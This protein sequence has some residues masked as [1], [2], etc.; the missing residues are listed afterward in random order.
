[1]IRDWSID[2]LSDTKTRPDEAMRSAMA[3]ARVGDEQQEEDPTVDHLRKRVAALFGKPQ[4]VFL[5]S[6]TMANLI[7]I[8][9][10]C[11]RGDEI[12]A[13]ASS[14]VLH[15]ETGGPAG[16][17]GATVTALPGQRGMFGLQELSQAL[18][19][20]RRNA[21][22]PRLVWIEQT[23][24]LAGG[25]VWPLD[26][27]RPIR[28]FCD[29][30]GLLL[31]IDGARLMNAAIAHRVEAAAYGAVADSLWL[32]FSKG[33]GAP[34]GAVLA[35]SEAFVTAAIRYKHM[36][37]GA[38][39]QG[40]IMAAACLHALDHN[41]ER[42][43]DD[44]A[45]AKALAE[46]LR[47]LK[48]IVIDGEVETNIVIANLDSN[49]RLDARGVADALASRGIRVGV[50]GPRTMR[51]VTHLH[52]TAEDVATTVSAMQEIMSS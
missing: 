15:F 46:G 34:F 40:G 8:L 35:G 32:D 13:E 9:V 43:A 37:G 42:L 12:L 44:H 11:G 25:T 26:I 47:E 6:G 41:I 33:L 14:H 50:F 4:A 17:A 1:M 29:A 31:H 52:V 39:R 2:L 27:L 48:G 30:E 19:S 28:A 10:H 22:R 16:I 23:T 24:N 49:S 21:P 36:L 5:P 45:N 51:L 3:A 18:R 7:S 38:M 20:P